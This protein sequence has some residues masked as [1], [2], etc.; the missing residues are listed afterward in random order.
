MPHK[1]IGQQ[2]NQSIGMIMDRTEPNTNFGRNTSSTALELTSRWGWT[3]PPKEVIAAANLSI[4]L[5]EIKTG[6]A[7]TFLDVI[8]QEQLDKL[9][10]EKPQKTKILEFAAQQIPTI[11]P[12]VDRILTLKTGYAYYES[13]SG[14]NLHPAMT[15]K[16]VHLKCEELDAVVLLIE[17][18]IPVVVFS[19]YQKMINY[20]TAGR[21][22]RSSDVIRT[23]ALLG[24]QS[25]ILVAVGKRDIVISM[26]SASKGNDGGELSESTESFWLG[27]AAIDQYQKQL[28]R[29]LDYCI[30]SKVTDISI[31]PQRS[32]G[33]RNLMRL[34]GDLIDMP[35]KTMNEEV[36]RNIVN[37]LMAKSGANPKSVRIFDPADGQITYRSGAGDVFL[38]LSFIPLNHPG[39]DTQLISI[40]IR[41]LPRTNTVIDLIDLKIAPNVRA[42]ISTAAKFPQGLILLC[43]GTNTGKSTTISAAL[44]ENIKHFGDTRKRISIEQPIERFLPGVIQVNV[45]ERENKKGAFVDGF[46]KILRAIKRHDPDVIWVGEIRD[47][48]S[49]NVCVA[50][51]ISGHLVFSTIHANH[52]LLGY[53][54]LSKMVHADQRYQLIEALSLIIAQR[55]VKEVCPKCGVLGSPNANEVAMFEIF[56]KQQSG[57]SKL[58][59]HVIH[60]HPEGC[61]DCKFRG[62]IGVVPI[63]EV[64]PVTYDVKDAMLS[65]LNN[66]NKRK[67]IEDR[68]TVTMFDSAMSLVATHR[69]EL[70]S[71]II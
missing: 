27:A 25:D 24:D 59:S 22:V 42:S 29:M 62:Y 49:A 67:V 44:G 7:L 39:E 4:E 57:T 71:A 51:A 21:E 69:I 13:L 55:L 35:S 11:R 40:S 6:S 23:A 34:F 45:S 53:D 16:N 43:G 2:A 19:S 18:E 8:K 20:A 31:V 26:L 30:E 56:L 32:G 58:P 17:E 54:N 9:L 47:Q 12:M 48:Q 36:Y 37:F 68:R 63:N 38:R 5:K 66:E 61:P 65:M 28:V 46:E 52:T 10:V 60:A 1:Y 14:L 33:A 3:K 70:G 50:S 15:A 64:L 41:I